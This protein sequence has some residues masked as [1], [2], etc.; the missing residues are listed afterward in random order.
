MHLSSQDTLILL[1]MSRVKKRRLQGSDFFCSKR[2]INY[3]DLLNS[4]FTSFFSSLSAALTS[5]QPLFCSPDWC[6]HHYYHN[7]QNIGKRLQ[8]STTWVFAWD[9]FV[10]MQNLCSYRTR[11][12]IITSWLERSR[13]SNLCDGLRLSTG[14][15][16]CGPSFYWST[17]FTRRECVS[18]EVGGW[19]FLTSVFL[20]TD[21]IQIISLEVRSNHKLKGK[22]EKLGMIKMFSGEIHN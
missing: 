17:F 7:Y 20:T 18:G 13:S 14:G 4:Q 5:F 12:L 1:C 11:K 22:K 3:K 10:A 2:K 6:F 15:F 9:Y 21:F 16:Q 8:K 19:S